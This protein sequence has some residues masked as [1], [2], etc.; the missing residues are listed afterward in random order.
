M[1]HNIFASEQK[2]N[3]LLIVFQ[4]KERGGIFVYHSDVFV[5][6]S[7]SFCYKNNFGYVCN[8]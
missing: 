2:M 1:A 6:A 4:Q 7:F 5:F 8:F 3:F